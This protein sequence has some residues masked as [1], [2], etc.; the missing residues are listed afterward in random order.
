[1]IRALRWR[2]PKRSR[3]F[4]IFAPNTKSPV[5]DP[6]RVNPD[7]YLSA[8]GKS[9]IIVRHYQAG[10]PYCL[11][12][13]HW[14]GLNPAKGVGWRAFTTVIERIRTCFGK[15]VGWMRPSDITNRYHQAGGW[16]FLD[17]I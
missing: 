8:D 13:A 17:R 16:S 1:M 12:Y 15:Q 11:W 10:L 14:Q 5:N 2:A 4:W 3:I 6:A 9:G 7:Y